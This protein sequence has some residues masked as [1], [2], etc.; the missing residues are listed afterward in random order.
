MNGDESATTRLLYTPVEAA[1]ALGISRSTLY[2]LLSNGS[3][4]SVRIGGARRIALSEL[5]RFI[6]HL[7]NERWANRHTL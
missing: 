6:E 5:H 3:L 2:V 1:E 7:A 4:T